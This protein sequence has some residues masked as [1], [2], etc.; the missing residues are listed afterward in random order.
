MDEFILISLKTKK[1][2]K[3]LIKSILKFDAN[4]TLFFIL[5]LINGLKNTVEI[6]QEY[7][8]EL[9]DIHFMERQ[10]KRVLENIDTLNSIADTLKLD[11][12]KYKIMLATQNKLKSM[13]ALWGVKLR[14]AR[15]INWFN[16]YQI[17]SLPFVLDEGLKRSIVAQECI[18]ENEKKDPEYDRHK[19]MAENG[20]KTLTKLQ[21][22]LSYLQIY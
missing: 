21:D 20:L 18:L 14:L 9:K 22:D 4:E 3:M 11:D 5:A 7:M 10:Y 6:L 1:T 15:N 17:S 13:F 16:L 2:R 19:E 12:E 8:E